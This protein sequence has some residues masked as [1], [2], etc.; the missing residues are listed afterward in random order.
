MLGLA[1]LFRIVCVIFTPSLCY[2]EH[3][4]LL[5][6]HTHY[7]NDPFFIVQVYDV[8]QFVGKIVGRTAPEYRDVYSHITIFLSLENDLSVWWMELFSLLIG[9]TGTT[10]NKPVQSWFLDLVLREE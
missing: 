8:F 2:L 6:R 3:K 1:N 5:C 4:I 7:F 9:Y 10:A